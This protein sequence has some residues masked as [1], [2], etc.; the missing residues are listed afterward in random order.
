[1]GITTK[2]E[3]TTVEKQNAILILI[4]IVISTTVSVSSLALWLPTVYFKLG[5]LEK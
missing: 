3:L 1:M 5:V 2:I 4:V